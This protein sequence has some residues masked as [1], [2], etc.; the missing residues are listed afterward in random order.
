MTKIEFERH[1]V[2]MQSRMISFAYAILHSQHEAEDLVSDIITK[3]WIKREELSH[4]S[5]LKSYLFVAVRNGAYDLIRSRRA[6]DELLD[7]L[8]DSNSSVERL[9]NIAL[10]R[11]AIST[12]PPKQREVLHLKE[13]EGYSVEEISQLIDAQA[14]NVRMILSRA[15]HALRDKIIEL[16]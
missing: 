6:S 8:A 9:D 7:T 14:T 3:L 13:I 11:H 1:I 15:R 10:V 2:V 5:N 16:R 4:Y 12:L